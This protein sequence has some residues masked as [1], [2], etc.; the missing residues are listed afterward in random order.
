MGMYTE[1]F[2]R[3]RLEKDTPEEV[4][5]FLDTW[6]NKRDYKVLAQMDVPD[7]PLFKCSR[8]ESLAGC[9]SY[10]FPDHAESALTQDALFK[11]WSLVINADLKNYSGEI[12]KFF[13][14]INPYCEAMTGEFLG[15]E[16]YEDV[17][18]GQ[19]PTPYFK[20]ES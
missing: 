11:G 18:P 17:E 20:K 8:W 1:I 15:Y 16:L 19:A 12:E 9:S 3:S 7:H 6:V 5:T 13:D 10:Y 2:F 14:W 4:I